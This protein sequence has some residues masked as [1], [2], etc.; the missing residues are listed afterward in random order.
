M[1]VEHT[2]QSLY[3][4]WLLLRQLADCEQATL[5]AW[6]D[7]QAYC[8][9]RG[10]DL[11]P[12]E[13]A[14]EW[15]ELNTKPVMALNWLASLYPSSDESKPSYWVEWEQALRQAIVDHIARTTN[16]LLS[17]QTH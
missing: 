8:T 12:Y 1:Q 13:N 16:I 4:M 3:E 9:E 15:L 2:K 10:Y 5:T 6:R 7:V 17:Y 11:V 14:D